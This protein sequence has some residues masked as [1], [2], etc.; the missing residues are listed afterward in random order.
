M[1]LWRPDEDTFSIS[2]LW[3][4][5]CMRINP[6]KNVLRAPLRFNQGKEENGKQIREKLHVGD[7]VNNLQ[8]IQGST[9]DE[10]LQ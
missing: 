9:E 7:F 2:S 6:V 8:C 5:S 1:V 3:Y 10:F 4:V